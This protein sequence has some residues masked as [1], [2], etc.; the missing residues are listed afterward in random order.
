LALYDEVLLNGPCASVGV[1]KNVNV[2]SLGYGW[3]IVEVSVFLAKS[4]SVDWTGYDLDDLIS[5]LLGAA[6]SPAYYT[7]SGM[8]SMFPRM[9]SGGLA[10]YEHRACDGLVCLDFTVELPDPVD[11]KPSP[12]REDPNA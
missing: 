7:V 5:S 4:K 10:Q 3:Q 9:A 8:L 1:T 12:A 2:D 11:I 6:L